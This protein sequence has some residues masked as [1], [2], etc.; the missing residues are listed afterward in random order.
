MHIT[1]PMNLACKSRK[2]LLEI[3]KSKRL[4]KP[5]FLLQIITL[6]SNRMLD[7]IKENII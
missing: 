1:K 3:V 6:I 4:S 7:M 2:G 5:N